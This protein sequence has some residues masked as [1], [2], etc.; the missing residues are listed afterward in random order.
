MSFIYV[1]QHNIHLP[2][3]HEE[4]SHKINNN[5]N[6]AKKSSFLLPF[7]IFPNQVCLC[8]NMINM[9]TMQNVKKLK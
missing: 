6:S 2:D 7:F 1:G 8:N 4:V 3:V 5:E 9:R